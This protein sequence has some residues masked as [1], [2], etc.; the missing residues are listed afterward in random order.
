MTEHT[1]ALTQHVTHTHPAVATALSTGA[2]HLPS[3]CP[4]R[5]TLVQGSWLVAF[6]YMAPFV[7]RLRSPQ[8]CIP[9]CYTRRDQDSM[10]WGGGG[11]RWTQECWGCSGLPGK[12]FET[13]QPHFESESSNLLWPF[14]EC[15]MSYSVEDLGSVE[16]ARTFRTCLL[17]LTTMT[18]LPKCVC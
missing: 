4:G 13:C 6:L 2:V 1:S 12:G 18:P 3:S 17:W 5:L 8:V 15:E 16:R 11:M 9:Q 7:P 10:G 14:R